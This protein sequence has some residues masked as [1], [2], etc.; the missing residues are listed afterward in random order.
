M[1]QN[2][3]FNNIKKKEATFYFWNNLR[4]NIFYQSYL[5]L[6]ECLLN[7]NFKSTFKIFGEIFALFVLWRNYSFE[8]YSS[9]VIFSRAANL[10]FYLW[11]TQEM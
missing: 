3:N 1:W 7:Q 8:D 5:F 2:E 11:I 6:S 4:F 9:I 10:N